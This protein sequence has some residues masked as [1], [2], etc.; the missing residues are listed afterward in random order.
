MTGSQAPLVSVII[1]AFNAAATLAET[2]ASVSAQSWRHLEIFVIDDGSTD[3]TPD[4]IAAAARHD[5]RITAIHQTN[6]GVGAA[7]NAG[8]ARASGRYAAWLDADDLWH[9]HKIARQLDVFASAPEPLG[10]VYTGHRI[11]D[12]AG[13]IQ[14]N[15]RTLADVSGRTLCLQIATTY[16]T[17]LSSLMAPLALARACG[18]HDPALRAAGLE[19]A[20]DLLLQLRLARQAPAGFVPEALVGY[21]IHGANMSRAVARAARSNHLAYAMLEAEGVPAPEWVW[22]RGYG[23]MAGFAL[24]IL[25]I[26][27]PASAAAFLGTLM[28]RAPAETLGTLAHS[29]PFVLR[30]RLGLRPRDPALGQSFADADPASVPIE[31]PMLLS[32]RAEAR[33][34]AL[35]RAGCANAR[36]E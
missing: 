24:Q 5:P 13:R 3:A 31:G 16:F 4:V 25:A 11:I 34:R 32:R 10:F 21:R 14:P 30:D 17:N 33:L 15:P 28:S 27:S 20:E 29:V 26:G 2:I 7:R 36:T 22:R 6:Q 23:R 35:D 19:G 9:P 1:P 18:G 8:L 12:A